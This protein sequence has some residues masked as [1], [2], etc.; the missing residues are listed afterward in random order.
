MMDAEEMSGTRRRLNTRQ[1]R[2]SRFASGS[3]GMNDADPV[4]LLIFP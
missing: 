3:L 1:I 4:V 2:T